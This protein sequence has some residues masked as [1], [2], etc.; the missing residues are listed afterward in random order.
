MWTAYSIGEVNYMNGE[1]S[2]TDTEKEIDLE[3]NKSDAVAIGV[4]SILGIV[5]FGSLISEIATTVIP[6][7]RTER[8]VLFVE[9][10]NEKLKYLNKEVVELKTKSEEFADLLQD[11]FIQ[12]SRALSRERL[13]ILLVY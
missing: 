7:Q 8:I 1:F 11:G 12:A 10:L 5:P 6:N 2:I 4:K 13:N 3:S 9:V